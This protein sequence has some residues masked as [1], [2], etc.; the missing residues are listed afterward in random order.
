MRKG[1]AL[2]VLLASA[3]GCSIGA[4]ATL[5]L[6]GASVEPSYTCPAGSVDAPYSLH[7]VI[8]V[9]N[10][11]SKSVTIQSVTAVMTLAAVKGPWLEKVGE[12][13]KASEVMTS[14]TSLGAGSTAPMEVVI[15][16]SCTKGKAGGESSFGDY[17]VGFTVTTSSG[18][19]RIES[20]NRHRI[21]AN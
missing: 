9:H 15:P 1:A 19:Y 14:L 8:D 2:L 20:G 12:T 17:S 3:A 21:V 5:S 4:P 13:Y 18:T 7:G 6:T 11:T 10:G 16:S